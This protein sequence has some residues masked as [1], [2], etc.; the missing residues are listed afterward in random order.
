MNELESQFKDSAIDFSEGQANY[1]VHCLS[2]MAL[3]ISIITHGV[4]EG[5]PRDP[6]DESSEPYNLDDILEKNKQLVYLG[7]YIRS[8]TI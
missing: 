8:K 1:L 2:N 3:S 7:E 4:K 6:R 5:C